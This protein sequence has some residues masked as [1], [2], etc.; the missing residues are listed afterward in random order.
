MFTKKWSNCIV[1]CSTILKIR[2]AA[3]N[4]KLF[5]IS[6]VLCTRL[7]IQWNF[8]NLLNWTVESRIDNASP[9]KFNA[10]VNGDTDTDRP[11]ERER[12]KELKLNWIRFLSKIAKHKKNVEKEKQDTSARI[13]LHVC[14]VDSLQWMN[15]LIFFSHISLNNKIKTCRLISRRPTDVCSVK[16]Y[17]FDE[18]SMY[19]KYK[20]WSSLNISSSSSPDVT[21]S[22]SSDRHHHYCCC[23]HFIRSQKN[24]RAFRRVIKTKEKR[25]ERKKETRTQR[26]M[27][28]V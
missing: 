26:W 21:Q 4:W 2:I 25:K 13:N 19:L 11:R 16:A 12:E 5:Q 9:Y 22:T 7:R 1:S 20:Y 3:T 14:E 27:R 10:N 17:D 24:I 28:L 18:K 8:Q 6:C 23:D 15:E